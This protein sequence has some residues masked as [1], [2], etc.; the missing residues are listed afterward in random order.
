MY[1]HTPGS[2]GKALRRRRLRSSS[3]SSRILS[4]YTAQCGGQ[5]EDSNS[6]SNATG[7]TMGAKAKAKQGESRQAKDSSDDRQLA[8]RLIA[9][10]HALT[11][12]QTCWPQSRV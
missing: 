12:A 4:P 3:S 9:T 10:R 1:H 5:Q 6:S 2:S 7:E 8:G 11:S